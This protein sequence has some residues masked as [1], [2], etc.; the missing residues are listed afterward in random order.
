MTN[1][2]AWT[3]T[4]YFTEYAKQELERR[5]ANSRFFYSTTCG[6]GEYEVRDDHV[7]FLVRLDTSS[8][9]CGIWQVFGIPYKYGLWVIYNQR[10]QLEEYVF[11]YFKGATYKMTY[12]YIA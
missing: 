4:T 1:R 12:A 9:G 7:Y 2:L 8:C 3:F 11:D 5:S 10:L 6:G